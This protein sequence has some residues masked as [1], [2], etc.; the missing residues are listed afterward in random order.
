[1]MILV[2]SLHGRTRCHWRDSRGRQ[3]RLR[4]GHD[5]AHEPM[6]F[7][8]SARRSSVASSG[9]ASVATIAQFFRRQ[10]FDG[11]SVHTTSPQSSQAT[12]V[13]MANGTLDLRGSRGP[14]DARRGCPWSHAYL[15]RLEGR[16][17]GS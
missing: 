15:L 1:M 10:S 8:S 9:N 12:R 17:V 5:G 11:S 4:I 2:K 3:C 7:R 16:R 6:G 13:S 14:P